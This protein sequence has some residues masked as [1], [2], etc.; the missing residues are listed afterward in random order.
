L[1]W[2]R[3]HPPFYQRMVQ[4]KREI[5]FLPAK[6]GL[7]ENSPDF[8]QMKAELKKVTAKAEDE[9]KER[10]SLLAPVQG[11]PAPEKIEYNSGDPIEILC[12]EPGD[13]KSGGR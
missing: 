8:D 7:S 3:T 1:S 13:G 6:E 11:C 4:S 9:E 5:L 10:P 12:P 2:F